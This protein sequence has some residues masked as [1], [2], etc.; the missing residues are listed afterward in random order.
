LSDYSSEIFKYWKLISLI[1]S[2][3]KKAN[4]MAKNNIIKIV[5]VLVMLLFLISGFSVLEY[6][7]KGKNFGKYFN[8]QKFENFNEN[9][10]SLKPINGKNNLTKFLTNL[11]KKWDE[12]WEFSKKCFLIQI[13]F[14][15]QLI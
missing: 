3:N 2:I 1:V 9:E 6:E 4:E 5:A 7:S 11:E 8:V 15:L 10:K 14:K 12:F 13:Q